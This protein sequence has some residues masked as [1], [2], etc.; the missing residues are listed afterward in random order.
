M[1]GMWCAPLTITVEG[2]SVPVSACVD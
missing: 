2:I 1:V